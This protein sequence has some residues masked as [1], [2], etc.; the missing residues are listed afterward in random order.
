MRLMEQVR[1]IGADEAQVGDAQLNTARQALLREIARS[2][3]KPARAGRAA[4]I[5][6][7]GS[8][9]AAAVTVVIAANAM[10]PAESAAAAVLQRAAD[11]VVTGEAFDVPAGSYLRIARTAERVELWDADMPDETSRFN[12]GDPADAEAGLRVRETTDLYVPSDR[13]ADWILESA[14]QELVASYGDQSDQAAAEFAELGEGFREEA[15]VTVA[16]GGAYPAPGANGQAARLDYIDGRDGWEGQPLDPREL[17][18]WL[19]ASRGEAPDSAAA[20]SSIVESLTQ[21]IA[22]A[23]A[24]PARRAAW[25]RALAMLE[26]S[27]VESVAGDVTTIRFSWSTEWWDA[28]R[29]VEIDTARGVILG[30]TSSGAL[31]E[32]E[33]TV[34][35]LPRWQSRETYSYD[36][37]DSAPTG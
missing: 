6:V 20:D 22:D 33:A 11:V 1:E 24:P 30:V 13:S 5:G 23:A 12:N 9:A 31:T 37:V 16:P 29:L 19:R 18:S 36:V 15:Q 4:W 7:S 27:S 3:R 14:P 8:A 32:A 21:D 28:W 26:G 34:D 10:V 2:E 17:L 35:G 25:L